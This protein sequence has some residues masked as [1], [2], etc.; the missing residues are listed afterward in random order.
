MR[1]REKKRIVTTGRLIKALKKYPPTTRM[2]WVGMHD[3]EF[4]IQVNDKVFLAYEKG[5]RRVVYIS[6]INP[7]YLKLDK[8]TKS[9]FDEENEES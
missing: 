1:Q 3:E 5:N 9:I 7:P 8:F 6:A 4:H 2:R